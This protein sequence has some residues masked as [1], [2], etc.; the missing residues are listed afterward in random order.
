MPDV[1]Y[2]SARAG[3]D[4]AY[5]V[6]NDFGERVG[7]ATFAV[8]QLWSGAP[9]GKVDPLPVRVY[10]LD[11]DGELSGEPGQALTGYLTLEDAE[12]LCDVLAAAIDEVRWT[13]HRR[14]T[15]AR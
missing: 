3:Y 6:V 1:M 2:D 5:E 15:A 13:R 14:R 12:E 10:V 9:T 8:D 4:D 7:V 11:T